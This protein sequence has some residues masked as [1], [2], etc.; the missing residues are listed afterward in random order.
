MHSEFTG[1]KVTIVGLGRSAL[2]AA[3]LL[4]HVGAIPFVSEAGDGPALAEW[5]AQIQQLAIPHEIGGHSENTFTSADAIVLSPGVPLGIAPLRAAREKGIPILSELELGYRHC[6]STCLAITGTNGKT[7]ATELLH[8][9]LLHCGYTSVLAGNNALP[10]SRA[11][12]SHPEARYAVIE[13]S[14]YQLETCTTFRPAVAAVLN[15]TPDHLARHGDMSGYA[16][17]KARIFAAQSSADIAVLNADDELVA[18][19]P[20]PDGV[21]RTFFSLGGYVERGLWVDGEVI[22]ENAHP[23]ASTRD[24][25]IPGRHNLANALAVLT[26]ARSIAL[27]W[28]SV[29]AGLRAFTGVEHRIEFVRD[30]CGV[31]YYNDSKS[32]NID[33]LRVALSSFER[34]IVLI[35]GGRGK[36]SDY[37]VLADLVRERVKHLITLGEDAPLLE[38]AFGSQVLCE[39]AAGMADAVDRARCAA[40]EGD[41]VLLSPGCAS[42][43]MYA[44]YEQRGEDF[45]NCVRTLCAQVREA[46]T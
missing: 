11:V 8:A 1:K 14:S 13:A 29:L 31:A 45:K 4:K 24:I 37:R 35:A 38:D 18:D 42:F 43:D 26:I 3:H 9:I 21:E 32:T 36:G 16:E 33:S 10:L 23:V 25:P 27:P 41:V 34:P 7:T 17:A 2:G 30:L 28:D 39:R 12:L 20:T 22:R 46:K 40:N 6:N 5:R 15:L 19:L 44:N